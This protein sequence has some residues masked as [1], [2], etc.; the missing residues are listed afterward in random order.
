MYSHGG[1]IVLKVSVVD[2]LTGYSCLGRENVDAG[3]WVVYGRI[4]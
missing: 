4:R 3:L 1:F 2:S